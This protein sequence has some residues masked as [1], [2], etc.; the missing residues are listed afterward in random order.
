MLGWFDERRVKA[1]LEVPAK[2]GIALLIT[3]GYPRQGGA[4]EKTRKTREEIRSWNTYD[5]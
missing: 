5:S 3:V 4:P 2:K 1:I